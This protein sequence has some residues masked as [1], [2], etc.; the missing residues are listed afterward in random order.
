METSLFSNNTQKVITLNGVLPIVRQ[1]PS[2]DKLKLIRILVEE[3][4][5]NECIFPFESNKVYDLPTPYN[6][7]GAAEVLMN[8]LKKK[9]T[10]K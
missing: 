2:V 3:L 9:D 7:F 6:T 8:T 4:D 5:K 10:D 1:L